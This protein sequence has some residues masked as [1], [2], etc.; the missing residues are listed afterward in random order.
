MSLVRQWQ[1][2]RMIRQSLRVNF[3]FFLAVIVKDRLLAFETVDMSN[4]NAILNTQDA[5]EYLKIS[6][7]GLE[8]RCDSYS[9]ESVRCTFE[10]KA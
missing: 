8:A 7:D 3:L 2:N 1:C 5:S 9:F 10:V 6:G 4:I